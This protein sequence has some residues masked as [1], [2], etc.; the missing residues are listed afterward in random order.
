MWKQ[1]ERKTRL[2]FSYM[3]K[4]EEENEEFEKR[5][6]R[7]K[8]EVDYVREKE[9]EETREDKYFH[10]RWKNRKLRKTKNEKRE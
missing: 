8:K 7:R 4:K 6:K 3:A 5:E 9:N 1:N 10:G 2:S